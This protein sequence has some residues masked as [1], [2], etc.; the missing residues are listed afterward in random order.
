[1]DLLLFSLINI[2]NEFLVND[3]RGYAFRHWN[4]DNEIVLLL[5]KDQ[6]GSESFLAKINEGIRTALH[7]R[8][9][10]GIGSTHSFPTDMALSYQEARNALRQRNLKSKETWIHSTLQTA[11]TVQP[12]LTFSQYEERIQLA[13]RSG[14]IDQIQEKIQ[15]WMDAVKLSEAITLEQLDHWWR[16]YRVI[17]R[18]WVQQF[19]SNISEDRVKQLLLDEPSSLI[20]PLDEYGILSFS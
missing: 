12:A 13:I 11:K 3:R 2:C 8:V 16:E 17:K 18:R 14:S 9:D 1:L 6:S 7:T 5:W 20:V 10:F 19:F 4:S 15:E